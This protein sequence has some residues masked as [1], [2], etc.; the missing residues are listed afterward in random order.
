[1]PKG[2]TTESKLNTEEQISSIWNLGGLSLPQLGKRVWQEIE[3]DNVINLGYELAYNFLLAIFPLLLFLVT[4]FGLF[5]SE[6]SQLKQNLFFYFSQVLPPSAYDVVTKTINEVTRNA[7]GGKLT[8]GL[9][10]A[11]YSASGGMTTMMSGLNTAYHVRESR[12]WIKTHAIAV[13]LTVAI[14]ALVISAMFLVLM[15]GH[16]APLIGSKL[17]MGPVFVVG[18]KVVQW[19]AA[20]F[21]I[22]FAFSLIYYF[23]PDLREQH[24]YWITPGSVVGVLLWIVAS[25]GFRIYLHYF[26]SYSKT[27]GSLGAVIVLLLWFY[28]TGLAFL[29]GGEVNAEIEHAAAEHG[30]PEAKAEGEKESPEG[31]R[32]A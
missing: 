3:H 23:G 26:N 5:A 9:V 14:S 18:W 11:L 19:I 10:F 8:F 13:A 24:W 31:K 16:L 7:G 12:S 6:G 17:G 28:I 29:V 25:F 1:M 27:Y 4:L 20:L 22:V 21:F 2:P 32:A 15:G 30:H